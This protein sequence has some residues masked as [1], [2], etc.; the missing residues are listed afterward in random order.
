MSLSKVILPGQ[1][2]GIIGGGQLG[3]M[4]TL[5]AKAMG[6][7]VVVLDPTPDGPCAQ[8]ADEQIVASYDSLPDLENL[9][10]KSEVITYE[11][12]NISAEALDLLTKKAYIPQGTELLRIT[13]NRMTEKTSISNAGVQVAPYAIIRD[14]EDV[15]LHLN[16]TGL[17]AVLKTTTGGY[18]GKGQ[19]VIRHPDDL[20][21]VEILLNSGPCILEKWIPFTKEISVMITRNVNGETSIFPIAEN[22]HQNN[23]L[24]QTIVPARIT[25][26]VA[27]QALAAAKKLADY[28]KLVGTMAVEMFVT[29]H[30]QI[31]INE[32]APRPH[33][34][35]HF[36]IE[37][38][39]TSQFEQHIRAIANWPLGKT[40][41]LKPAVMV[42]IL[43]QHQGTILKMIPYLK[44][45]KIHLY[46]K[47]E[48]KHNRKMGHVT[49]LRD[50][51]EDAL[52]EI[53][54]SRI[55]EESTTFTEVY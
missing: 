17:P 55:W 25:E 28:F 31:Y 10:Q 36:S 32:L 53:K 9:A 44:D 50:N 48:A 11:F 22:L 16:D 41:L 42:N 33:N 47:S 26:D 15:H 27:T 8:V 43:G 1:T 29:E 54:D 20:R 51:I 12:E 14:I 49:L 24:H 30:N 23:I 3:K 34:S 38:C 21:K 40:N 37:A 52:K 46:G 7:R 2:I 19:V 18:D 6:F 45:W 35:G 39:Q 13:Q 4:M 5:S